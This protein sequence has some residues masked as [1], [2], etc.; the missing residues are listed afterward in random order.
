MSFLQKY[1]VIAAGSLLGVS[2]HEG[3]SFPV[4]KVETIE[5]HPM[6]YGEFFTAMG[7]ETLAGLIREKDYDAVNMFSDRYI[8]WLKLCY[9]IGGMPEAVNDYAEN[10]D[11]I[12]V[13]EIQNEILK[14][15]ENDFGKHT[16]DSELP[17]IRM[18]WNSV[19]LQLAKENKKFFFGQIRQGARAKD[20]ELAIEW[21]L[22]CGLVGKVY[23]VEKPAIPLKAYIDFSAFKIC[24]LDI[25][26]LGAMS[27]LDARSILEGNDLFTEFKGALTEQYVYQQI[28]AETEYT[29][30]YFSA[31][32]H[33]EID[34]LIQKEGEV[35]P[36]E[37]KAQENVKAKS[38]KAYCEKYKPAQAVRTSMANYREQDWLTNLPLY[39]VEN[40]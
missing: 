29:P 31:S 15:Y 40:L 10:G 5:I 20:F 3:V 36:V 13:R 2:I 37:V 19:P 32:S 7:E 12:T 33:N 35:V 38:L 22:D 25:G 4:G 39:A 14:L 23:R 17:R 11:I 6:S 1:A 28:V 26:L 16:P 21:L 27:E 9:Y 30:Y 24:L 34:F 8:H 18:V